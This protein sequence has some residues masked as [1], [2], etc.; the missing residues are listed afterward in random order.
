MRTKE[1]TTAKAPSTP[2]HPDAEM[3]ARV[4]RDADRIMAAITDPA[5]AVQAALAEYGIDMEERDPA[6]LPA[7]LRDDFHAFYIEHIDGTR[8]M[9]VPTGQDPHERLH[10][11]RTLL[12]HPGVMPV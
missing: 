5:A 6:T 9:V 2:P 1:S 3:L 10:W 8:I 11:V 7:K 4:E 12:A